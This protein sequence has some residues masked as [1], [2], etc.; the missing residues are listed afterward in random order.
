LVAHI[1]WW[2]FKPMSHIAALPVN[3]PRAPWDCMENCFHWRWRCHG[4]LTAFPWRSYGDLGVSMELHGV[5]TAFYLAIACALIA[6]SR[7]WYLHFVMQ[8]C[9]D[10]RPYIMYTRMWIQCHDRTCMSYLIL[11]MYTSLLLLN[12]IAMFYG[13]VYVILHWALIWYWDPHIHL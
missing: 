13:T 7:Q 8:C 3:F 11:Y 6:L 10:Y 1:W 2:G 4:I 5:P 9:T 12:H